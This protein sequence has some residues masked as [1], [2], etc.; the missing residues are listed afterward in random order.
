MP[1]TSGTSATRAT[2]MRHE[3]DTSMASERLQREEQFHSMNYLLQMPCFHAKM[4]LKSAPQKLNFLMTKAI[5][6]SRTLYVA[7]ERLQGEEQFHSTNYLLQMPCFHAKMRLK[8]APHKLKFFNDQ[9]Y[10]KT[11]YTRL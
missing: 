1:D 4:R 3:Y 8:S 6:N 11:L 9:S 2:Q 7:S 5:S 10:I